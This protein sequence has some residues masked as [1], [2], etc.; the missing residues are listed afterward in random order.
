MSR[1]AVQFLVT[2]AVFTLFMPRQSHS[3]TGLLDNCASAT[4]INATYDAHG[5]SDIYCTVGEA[6]NVTNYSTDGGE[7]CWLFACEQNLSCVLYNLKTCS[8]MILCD[9]FDKDEKVQ[10]E[11]TEIVE[12]VLIAFLVLFIVVLLVAVFVI[13]TMTLMIRDM[14]NE[15]VQ[16]GLPNP[17]SCIFSLTKS[18]FAKSEKDEGKGKPQKK[19]EKQKKEKKPKISESGAKHYRQREQVIYS[20]TELSYGKCHEYIGVTCMQY[21]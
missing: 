20:I 2:V 14:K 16:D 4:R 9:T 6:H 5:S 21:V 10:G 1:S 3:V 19:A 7:G 11:M 18:L 12:A 8:S 15:R 17:Y 13:L